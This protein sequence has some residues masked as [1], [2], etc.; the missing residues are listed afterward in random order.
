MALVWKHPFTAVVSG[1]TGCGK[2]SFVLK[3]IAYAN[4]VIDPP[5]KHIVWCYG[6]YQDIFNTVENVEFHDGIPQVE[7]LQKKSLLI[8]DDLMHEADD[9]INKIFTKYSHHKDIS[10]MFLT[11]NLFHKDART[12]TLNSHY[13]VIFKNPRDASQVAYLARQMFPGRPKYMVDAFTDATTKPYNYLVVD[14]KADTDDKH[15]L[16]SGIFPD[17][18]NFVY[19]PK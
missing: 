2:T 14:L 3:F 1:P 11:Q 9:R 12:I 16:R 7:L 8:L 15:R 10:V 18:D 13:L 17:D 4:Q 5:P 19:L 6:T